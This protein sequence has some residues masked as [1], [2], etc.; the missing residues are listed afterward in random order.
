M[1]KLNKV[2]VTFTDKDLNYLNTTIVK[3][4]LNIKLIGLYQLQYLNTTIVKV[5]LNW[6]GNC[7]Y[8]NTDLNTTIVKVKPL[9]VSPFG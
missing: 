2:K 7:F 9:A 5:K 8:I 4:K 3:V 6:K 1:L